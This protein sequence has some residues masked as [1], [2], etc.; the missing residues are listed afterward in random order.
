MAESSREPEAT[1]QAAAPPAS[2]DLPNGSEKAGDAQH[3]STR[4]VGPSSRCFPAPLIFVRIPRAAGTSLQ[5]FLLRR[6]APVGQRVFRFTGDPAQREEFACLPPEQRDTWDLLVGHVQFG[7]HELLSRPATYITMLRDP[8]ERLISHY[9]YVLEQPAHHLHR[10]IVENG[11][12]LCDYVLWPKNDE[13]DN[14]Q[15]RWLMSTPRWTVP[16][17]ALTRE[18]LEQAVWN[19]TNAFAVVGLAERFDDTVRCVCAAFGWEPPAVPLERL[20]AARSRPA[21]EAIPAATLGAIRERNRYDLELYDVARA[22]FEEQ[23]LRF[24]VRPRR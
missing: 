2:Q 21:R 17:G 16:N 6:Y 11:W 7:V 9:Y 14:D 19:L 10:R 12:T 5:Q 23:M 20:N 15:V 4:G 18:M 1:A 8:V 3:E 22:L 13:A 24:G